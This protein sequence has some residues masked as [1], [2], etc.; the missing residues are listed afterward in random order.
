[1]GKQWV[2][3][4][5]KKDW[6]QEVTEDLTVWVSKNQQT[7]ALA[8]GGILAAV[9]AIGFFV[10]RTHAVQ[11]AAWDRLALAEDAYYSGQPEAAA[12]QIQELVGAYPNSAAA[13]YGLLFQA[14]ILY[15]RGQ[16]KEALENYNK[17][18]ERGQ[19]QV[20]QPLA[21]GGSVLAQEAAGQ[22]QPAA[23]GAQHFLELY[24]DHFLAPQVHASLARCEQTQGLTEQAR[25][26]YQKIT[27]QYPDTSW[28]VWAKKRLDALATGHK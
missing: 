9:A 2:R 19:P 13:S 1:M 24:A 12:K 7:A 8:A 10:Y 20:L 3:Q 15:P 16:Y 23:Q 22:C 11:S 27:L 21:L 14:D 25:N 26:A 18:L 6:L 28:A 4:E 17:I 5:V